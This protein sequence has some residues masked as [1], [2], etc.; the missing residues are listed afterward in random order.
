MRVIHVKT[1]IQDKT[2]KP[3]AG[4]SNL[5]HLIQIKVAIGQALAL[6]NPTGQNQGAVIELKT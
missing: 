1:P 5:S 3:Q 2:L 4:S 6:T